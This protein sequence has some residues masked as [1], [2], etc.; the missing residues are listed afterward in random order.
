[1]IR[2]IVQEEAARDAYLAVESLAH[3]PE[4]STFETT[5]TYIVDGETYEVIV[6][7]T[8]EEVAPGDFRL[9]EVGSR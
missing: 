5:A 8:V 4:V 3:G 9:V 2:A 1:M 6:F 7:G